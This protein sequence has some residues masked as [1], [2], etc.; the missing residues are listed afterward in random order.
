MTDDVTRRV[1][2]WLEQRGVPHEVMH[3]DP[4]K[5]DTAAF[6]EAYGV[7][8]EDSANTLLVASK[9]EPK[10][11]AV[12]VVLATTRLDVNKAMCKLLGVK[13]ASFASADEMHALTGMRVGGVTPLALPEDLPVYVDSRVLERERVVVGGGGRDTKI[14][15]S[16]SVLEAMPNARVVEGL[17]KPVTP[18]AGA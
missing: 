4:E 3:I 6:C 5:A 10:R 17:A 9:K 7:A 15:L 14:A 12:G 2:A 8:L 13:R 18:A 1:Q 11:Y 16:P